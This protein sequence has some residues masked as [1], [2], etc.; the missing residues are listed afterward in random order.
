MRNLSSRQYILVAL[1]LSTG[2]GA[3]FA[4]AI[5]TIRD[6]QWDYA[7]QTN[8][9]L[10]HTIEENIGRTIDSFSFSLDG[11]VTGLARP[12]VQSL[13]APLMRT[14][15][16]DS[17][18]RTKGLGSVVVLNA[19]GDIVMD[20]SSEVARTGNLSDRDY[21]K[22]HQQGTV[23]GLF[24]A[25]P[26]RARFA[27]G[28]PSLPLS[29]AYF[30]AQGRF[31]GVVVGSIRLKYFDD[32]FSS[33]DIGP[34]SRVDLFRTDGMT[35][36][37]MPSEAA[38]PGSMTVDKAHLQRVLAADH[39]TFTSA[40]AADGAER[41]H[42]FRKVQN[43]PL[44]VSVAQSV[45]TILAQWRRSAVLL[46][47]FALVL[48]LSCVG[49]TQLFVRELARRQAVGAQLKKAERDLLTI[50]DNLP[51]MVAYWDSDLRNRFANQAYLE[52]LRVTPQALRTQ[53]L[54]SIM[55]A[56]DYARAR[57]H[58]DLAL[59]GQKQVFERTVRSPGG[60]ERHA[61][62]SYVP[63]FDGSRVQGFFVQIDD[64]TERK[65]MEDLLFEEKELV[66]LTLQAIGDAV[67][68][69][70][71]LGHITYLNPAAETLTGWQAFHAS[72]QHVDLVAPLTLKTASADTAD[73]GPSPIVRTLS[74]G[75][76]HPA[77]RGV[78]LRRRDGEEIEI[79]ES[80]SPITDR[81]GLVTGAV[82]ILRDVTEAMALT[83]RLAHLAQYDV[84]TDLPNRLL[85]QDRAQ[86]AIA[87]ALRDQHSLALMYLD[88]DGFKQVNDTLG[89]DAGDELLVQVARR[90]TAAVRQSDTVC[91]QGG[92]EFVVLL[93]ALDNAEQ[94]CV[95]AR[96]LLA[97]CAQPFDLHGHSCQIALSGGIAMHPQHGQNFEELARSADAAMYTAKRSGR[98]H[99][100][101]SM[102]PAQEA[103]AVAH[104]DH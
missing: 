72:G 43:Y 66:R 101:L 24:I 16:F 1:V 55:D 19:Q 69:T 42:A 27:G 40:D 85:L 64:L 2:I 26:V 30:D 94:A 53:R 62:V 11:I 23:Q 31:A 67:I 83:R 34:T 35:V 9:T 63:D 103:Q 39:G 96:K 92:D 10:A 7:L 21:F 74:E 56:R 65:R 97:A 3:L 77:Q 28:A 38:L 58:I 104:T 52:W 14:L 49:L 87:H 44:V 102:G 12:D 32:L 25:Q 5:L 82:M 99:F 29:R 54:P 6:S 79:E 70:D 41:M 95:V 51:S 59:Q 33:V 89:H 75:T 90:F 86:Q 45:D 76:A 84:L 100:R 8:S 37:A 15:L 50:L 81:N 80:A 71:A 36:A 61:L 4:R 22:V 93:P 18:L 68:C 73:A 57:V 98:G 78:V 88:L 46:G 20:S 47:G 17:S 13:P 48:M 60:A 91:R